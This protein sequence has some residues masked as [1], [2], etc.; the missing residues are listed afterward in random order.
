M[1]AWAAI[2]IQAMSAI[3]AAIESDATLGVCNGS[4][5]SWPPAGRD[6]RFIPPIL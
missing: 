3:A 2:A 1:S 5:G 4:S 6:E